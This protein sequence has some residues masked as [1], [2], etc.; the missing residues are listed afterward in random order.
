[1][2]AHRLLRQ[3][4]VDDH[5]VHAVV[6]E[7]LAH[8]AARERRQE[9]HRRRVGGGRRNDDRIV[10]RALLLQDLAELHDGGALLPYRPIA[11]VELDL[12]VPAPPYPLPISSPSA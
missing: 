8:G 7:E 11:P 1:S 5:R 3:V 2:V 9:L 12:F 6:A 10:E 4:V